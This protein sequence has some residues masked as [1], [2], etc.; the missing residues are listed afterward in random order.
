[1]NEQAIFLAALEITDPAERSAFLKKACDGNADLLR[2]VEALL[3]AHEKSG[4]FLDRPALGQMAGSPDATTIGNSSI[5]D[6]LDLSFLSPSAKPGSLGKLG[7]YE[8]LQV[9]GQGA[10]GTVLKAFDE[11]L[12][13]LVAIKVLSRELAATSPPRKRF[14]REARSVAAIKHENVIAI[15]SVEEQPIPYFVMEFVDG[16]TLQDKMDEAGPLGVPEILHIGKQIASGLASAHALGLIHR[17]IKPANILLEKGFVQKVKITDFGLARAADDASMTQSGTIV[18]TPLYMA[19]E[20][21]KGATLDARADLFSLGSVLYALATGH[22]PFRARTAIAVLRRVAEDTPRPMQEVISDIPDW[23]VAI[24]DKLLAKQ[25][26]DRFQ[27]AQEVADL[28]SKCQAELQT[29]GSVKSIAGLAVPAAAPA[30]PNAAKPVIAPQT[31]VPGPIPARGNASRAPS[32]AGKW[33]LAGLLLLAI[34]GFLYPWL[35]LELAGRASFK[36]LTRDGDTHIEFLQNGQ[37]IGE[38]TGY[39]QVELPAG[40]YDIRLTKPDTTQGIY[41]AIVTRRN[42]MNQTDTVT[43]DSPPQKFS[44][45]A[46]ERIE[47]MVAYMKPSDTAITANVTQPT[48]TM[49]PAQSERELAEWLIKQPGVESMHL[50]RE[51]GSPAALSL[52][53]G[54][55][56]PDGEFFV[57]DLDWREADAITDDDLTRIGMAQRLGTLNLNGKKLAMPKVTNRGL[58]QLVSPSVCQS[59]TSLGLPSLTNV[60]EEGYL[61]LNRASKLKALRLYLQQSGKGAFLS[62]LTD[63]RELGGLTIFG[64]HGERNTIPGGWIATLTDHMPKLDTFMVDGSPMTGADLGA[65]AKLPLRVLGITAGD[66]TDDDLAPIGDMTGL[67]S[68]SL[69]IMPKITD[70]GV[71]KLSALRQLENVSFAGTGVGDG[72]CKILA[73]NS[74]LKEVLL[75]GTQVTDAGLQELTGLKELNWLD[76]GSCPHVTVQGF[77]HLAVLPKLQQLYANGCM[78]LNNDALREIVKIQGLTTLS[79]IGNGDRITDAGLESLAKIGS[80]TDLQIQSNPQLTEAAV[81]KLQAALPKCKI[82]SDFP[83]ITQPTPAMTPAQSEREL[84]EWLIKQPGARITLV[85]EDGKYLELKTGDKLAN[86]TFFIFRLSLNAD[87]LMTDEGLARISQAERLND[88]TLWG[89]QG[90]EL[91][92]VTGKGLDRLFS[93]AVSRSLRTLQLHVVLPNVSDDDYLVLNRADNLQELSVNSLPPG[94]GSFLTRLDL[95]KLANFG[96]SG[97]DIP[98]GWLMPFSKRSP[99]L[100]NVLIDGAILTQTDIQA[101]TGL[102]LIT[103]VALAHCNLNDDAVA[104]LGTMSKL[105]LLNFSQIPEI[106]DERFNNF[107]G[108]KNL[109]NVSLVGC[110]VGDETCKTLSMLDKLETVALASTGLTDKGIETLTS[111]NSIKNLYLD[112]TRFTDKGAELLTSLKQLETLQLISCKRLTDQGLESLAKIGSLNYLNIATN[113][114]LTEAAVRKLKAALPK[115]KITSDFPNIMQPNPAM[116]PAQSDRELAEWLLSRP[117]GGNVILEPKIARIE[118][119]PAGTFQIQTIRFGAASEHMTDDDVI[120]FATRLARLDHPIIGIYDA[121]FPKATDKGIAAL[122][123][124]AVSKVSNNLGISAPVTDAIVPALNRLKRLKNLF[125]DSKNITSVG[126]QKL[127]LPEAVEIGF[128]HSP[129]NIEALED[130]GR[131]FPK[132]ERCFLYNDDGGAGQL[133]SFGPTRVEGLT[134]INAGVDDQA[135]R[136]I[137][138][139]PKL[140]WL[141]LSYNKGITRDGYDQ[142]SSKLDLQGIGLRA[143]SIDDEGLESL[144]KLKTLTDLNLHQN[145]QLTEAA[146]R[147]L[148]AALPKCKITSDFPN[149]TQPT[150][151]MTPAQS[152]RELAEWLIKQPGVEHLILF[153]EESSIPADLKTGDK[154]PD[155]SFFVTGLDWHEADAINDAD[156]ARIGQAQQLSSLQLAAKGNKFPFVTDKG[157]DRLLSPTVSKSLTQFMTTANY[158]NVTNEGYLVFNRARNLINLQFYSLESGMGAF[159]S[160]LNLP[161]LGGL[162]VNGQDI[163]GGWPV[164]LSQ[165]SHD[166]KVIGVQGSGLTQADVQVLSRMDLIRQLSLPLCG[167]DDEALI[168]LSKMTKLTYLNLVQ[169]PGITD[170]GTAKLA[171]LKE[172]TGIVLNACSVA[173]E[174]CKTLAALDKLESVGLGNTRLTDKGAEALTPLKSLK[175]LSLSGCKR[176]SDQGLEPLAKIGSLTDLQI[177]NN[178]QLTEAAVRK[179]QAALPKCKITSDFP[180]ITQPVPS[181]DPERAV[182]EWVLA[183]PGEKTLTVEG[184]GIEP[185]F[186]GAVAGRINRVEDLPKGPI[187]VH[188]VTLNDGGHV[189]DDDLARLGR[190]KKLSNLYLSSKDGKLANITDTGLAN[191][192]T[193]SVA[194]SLHTLQFYGTTLPNVNEDGYLALNQCRSLGDLG[195]WLPPGKG[196]FL[197]RLELPSS[198]GLI[199]IWGQRIPSGIFDKFATRLPKVNQL[200]LYGTDTQISEADVRALAESESLTS[201]TLEIA[202]GLNDR[203]LELLSK[204]RKLQWLVVP[205]RDITDNGIAHLA[206]LPDLKALGLHDTSVDDE[207]CKM[208]AAFPALEIL[209]LHQTRVTDAGLQHLSTGK[210]L[211]DLHLARCKQISDLGMDSLA[212]IPTLTTLNI[213]ANPQLTDKALES[214]AKLTGLMSLVIHGNPQLTEAAVRKLQAAMP[215]CKIISDFP[216]NTQPTPAMTPAQSERELAEWLIKQPGVELGLTL[217]D[218]NQP[219]LKTGDRLPDGEFFVT[220][221]VWREADA[222]TDDDLARIGT[223]QQLYAL[224]LAP[225]AGE[226][227][228]VTDKGLDQLFTPTVSK[229][230]FQFIVQS[231][232]PNVTEGGYL[233][234][235]RAQAMGD[236]HFWLPPGQGAFLSRLDLPK[237]NG[238]AVGVFGKESDVQ[239]IPRGWLVPFSRH[240]SDL[241]LIKLSGFRLTEPDVQALSGMD[242]VRTLTLADCGLDDEALSNLSEMTKLTQLGLYDC[243]KITDVGAARLAALKELRIL[244]LNGC[245]VGD[246]T[247]KTLA[248]LDKLEWIDLPRTRVTDQG[249]ETLTSLKSLK[250]LAL[251]DTRLTDKSVESLASIQG[252]NSLQLMGCKRLTDQGLESL[253]KIGSLTELQIYGNPQLTEAAVRKLQAALPKCKIISDFPNITQPTPAAMTPAQSERELAEWLIKQPGVRNFGL[254]LAKDGAPVVVKPGDRLPDAPYFVN[255]IDWRDGTGDITDNDLARIGKAQQLTQIE[256]GSKKG[257]FPNITD[258]GLTSLFSPSVRKSLR[259]FIPEDGFPK[260]TDDGYLV[261]NHSPSLTYLVI[262]KMP[263]GKGS[264][265]PGLTDLPKLTYFHVGGEGIEPGWIT[266]LP[267]RLPDLESLT[268]HGS[269]MNAED[270][271]ALAKMD[272]LKHLRLHA[273]NLKDDTLGTIGQIKKMT[274][275]S[276]D[277][278]SEI[279]DAGIDQLGALKE[280]T[281]LGLKETRVRDE[282]CKLLASLPKLEGTDLSG[283]RVSDAGIELISTSKSLKSVVLTEC[284]RISDQGLE[285][286]ARMTGLAHVHVQNNP[287]ITAAAVRKLQAALPKCRIVSDFGT[288]E[289][290]KD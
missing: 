95:P 113:P 19:P 164:P 264:F 37:V 281:Y 59:L 13:R 53:T 54:D 89:Q 262:P 289:P 70:R 79:V 138:K 104:L 165:R 184:E 230:L 241:T 64:R 208:L 226:L 276:L 86:G 245:S 155:G 212:Q 256:L 45:K 18:G 50:Y 21:A 144:S 107:A 147:K 200:N 177:Q 109:K 236:L 101:L 38:Q 238:F 90:L 280:L 9:L 61:A 11:K 148:Q 85:F 180:N 266:G 46:G 92:K 29:T 76:V 166:L 41:N 242:L 78:G 249:I 248:T 133:R 17:D 100:V 52:K 217:A 192:L 277:L 221:L 51:D 233:V 75:N 255:F 146:V 14:V 271:Q 273:C 251:M 63:L 22:A 88:L 66:L 162:T 83:N 237:L 96:V 47:F 215:K 62:K 159:L 189:T 127:E 10:F 106:T 267:S 160:Q 20:Q 26:D 194:T 191:L 34:G 158:P 25:P 269:G 123:E 82:T 263:A 211:K 178:P 6:E 129:L 91:S 210:M 141:D 139:L 103:G 135:M 142:L 31:P 69:Y 12:H 290:T 270:I 152:E 73:R 143:T 261:I 224:V 170:A 93:P 181:T 198:L 265:L 1:M 186:P 275:L 239:N 246:E 149:I 274:V 28:L 234:L 285:S 27:S 193:P 15:Y 58:D 32:Q 169:S 268:V 65:L 173:D 244:S 175:F 207:G 117:G 257:T 122:C 161:K 179:L 240:A 125:L 214:V 48:P 84:A 250:N 131:R 190:L 119:I 216:N 231:P 39:G 167:L 124:A 77:A 128:G 168:H 183:Q 118:D 282:T 116:T 227:S 176:L 136:E 74:K 145:P 243:P 235:N 42:W 260:V 97:H 253:S 30:F 197:S 105:T 35:R 206:N 279:T 24:V 185:L 201:V 187:W 205:G 49:T 120:A 2:K 8:V 126:M 81:R 55:K 68:L 114:Q 40:D 56:L 112:N 156:L 218:G 72:A 150:P 44:V 283:T 36:N 174:T 288:L 223:A 259:N 272:L 99:D 232:F 57:T 258:Q 140:S 121:N 195:L 163:P 199:Q 153:R 5:S 254:L 102:D 154:L 4:E 171:V 16:S 225:K 209:D 94:K 151:A 252:M 228:N 286:L 80:L 182:A 196:S 213:S 33:V 60:T 130:I 71:E 132:L 7:H 284:K 110:R 157:L 43:L 278:N 108:L 188:Q 287:Q 137:A 3:A 115:C 172:L 98:G 203:S 219:R 204:M 67:K 220:Y 222:V 111:R 87:E 134:L 202:N 247:C 229:S 23:L